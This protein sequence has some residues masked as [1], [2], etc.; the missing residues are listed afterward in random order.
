MKKALS[1][2]IIV[3]FGLFLGVFLV[4]AF[5][6]PTNGEESLTCEEI[7]QIY[8]AQLQLATPCFPKDA[9]KDNKG[10]KILE[11]L[12]EKINCALEAIDY[13]IKTSEEHRESCIGDP[14]NSAFTALDVLAKKGRSG[15]NRIKH[16][17]LKRIER[18]PIGNLC[19]LFFFI[20]S[21]LS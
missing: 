14:L 6:S 8:S 12:V 9:V 15:L 11:R 18:L 4:I 17:V 16:L 3:A 10:A 2:L 13:A 5:S 20:K 19:F 1:L 21:L 7:I